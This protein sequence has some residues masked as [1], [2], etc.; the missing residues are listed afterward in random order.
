MGQA[1]LFG[2][3]G[4]SALVVGGVL[5]AYWR[6]PQRVSGVLLAFAS[7]SLISALC[8]ELFPE[9]YELGGAWRAGLGL[10]A[11]GTAFVLANTAAPASRPIPDRHA[12]PRLNASSNSSNASAEMS[13]PLANA[14]RTPVTTRGGDQVA[15]TAAPI[16][17][18]LEAA[19]PNRTAV[20]TEAV[21]P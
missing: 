11:G 15:P 8:F 7:G 9:A 17:S 6:P 21:Y 16:T 12:P 1:L 18:A 2:L 10:L 5:G 4:S 20:S 3:I 19:S 14:S 13:A